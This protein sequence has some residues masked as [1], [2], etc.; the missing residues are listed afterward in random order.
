LI[1]A[2]ALL[3]VVGV[4][5]GVLVA[6]GG[7]S[8]GSPPS[9]IQARGALLPGVVL[10]GD[11]LTAR[12]DVTL[13]RSKIDP[14]SV[15]VQAGFAPW[16]PVAPPKQVRRDGS[17]SSTY[18]GKTYVLR[19]LEGACTSQNDSVVEDLDQARV[20][21][22]TRDGT[23]RVMKVKWPQ[24][25][26][27][28]RYAQKTLSAAGATA[29]PWKAALFS[30]PSLTYSVSPSLLVALLLIGGLVLLLAAGALVHLGR[31]RPEVQAAPAPAPPPPAP[32]LPP[33][34]RALLLLELSERVDGAGD[35][36]R[37]L[38]R[39]ADELTRRGEAELAR[40]AR[41]LAWSEGAPG[42]EQTIEFAAS[43]RPKITETTDETSS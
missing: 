7:G 41:A 39:V 37:A 10:F 19:C 11:T 34:E 21:Y 13:D 1:A 42:P 28:S 22:V 4:V 30:L 17:G 6:S 38:E 25:V 26:V 2:A 9:A 32:V 15:R 31:R 24:L 16:K 43:A 14:G 20:S 35:Q 36:R 27:D 33:L 12:L 40:R 8:G 29:A 23:H 18:I 3:V 5:A